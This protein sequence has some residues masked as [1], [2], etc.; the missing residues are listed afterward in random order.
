M[1]D[2]GWVSGK[3]MSTRPIF[4][5]VISC[6]CVFPFSFSFSFKGIDDLHGKVSHDLVFTHVRSFLTVSYRD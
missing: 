6:F 5:T 1:F 2:V 4:P 3:G